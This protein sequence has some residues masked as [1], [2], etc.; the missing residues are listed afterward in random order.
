MANTYISIGSTTVGSGGASSI[1]FSSIPSTYTDLILF[2]SLRNDSA[3]AVGRTVNVTFNGSTSGY[4]YRMIEHTGTNIYTGSGT[5][6]S[7]LPL[8][9]SIGPAATSNVF[10]NTFIYIPN[11]AGSKNKAV[12]SDDTMENDSSSIY[13]HVV[14]GMW[15]NTN[16]ITSIN[17]V[18]DNAS[19]FTQYS[20]AY[21]Y[22]IKNS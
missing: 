1:S 3:G 12:S 9:V 20:T 5:S 7:S 18:N 14:R 16:A 15:S 4:S 11:Y 19:N 10:S 6:A 22:G 21:L 8:A 17:L 2:L 13:S